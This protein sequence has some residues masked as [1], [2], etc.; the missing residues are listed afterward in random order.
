MASKEEK[1]EKEQAKAAK[2]SYKA[3]QKHQANRVKTRAKA[4]KKPAKVAKK[5][6]NQ[7]KSRT[8]AMGKLQKIQTN[9]LGLPPLL[10]PLM[11]VVAFVWARNVWDKES[12]ERDLREAKR[13]LHELREVKY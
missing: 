8:K 13:F 1:E 9:F 12:Q 4:E 5:Q 10:W 11:L 6:T 3:E 7:E 2:A